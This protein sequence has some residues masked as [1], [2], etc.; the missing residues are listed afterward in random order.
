MC[1]GRGYVL[2]Q[3]RSTLPGAAEQ[4]VHKG[5]AKGVPGVNMDEALALLT[6]VHCTSHVHA[7]ACS[8]MYA[9]ITAHVSGDLTASSHDICQFA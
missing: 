5:C 1:Y 2:S 7:L 6:S 4:R 9:A 8:A 3:V